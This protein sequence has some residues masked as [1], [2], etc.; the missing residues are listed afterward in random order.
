[1]A[2]EEGTIRAQAKRAK[3]ENRNGKE[4]SVPKDGRERMDREIVKAVLASPL[5]TPWPNIPSHLQKGVL[6]ALPKLVPQDIA[7]YHVSR[8]RCHQKEK[9]HK[10]K[11]LKPTQGQDGNGGSVGDAESHAESSQA[12]PARPVPPSHLAYVVLGIN[13]TIKELERNIDSLKL[14]LTMIA[15][16]LNA[17][18]T[19]TM[20]TSG[21]LPTAP[22]SPSP[23]IAEAAPLGWIVVPLLSISPRSLVSPIPQY[24]A[25]YNSLVYQWSQLGKTVRTRLKQ[26]KWGVLGYE[27]EEIR[28]V[29]LGDVEADMAKIAG[30]RR[31]A[32]IG[33]RAS[34]PDSKM[35]HDL[36]PKS[37]L[38]PPRHNITLPFP[39]SGLKVYTGER[40]E[41]KTDDPPAKKAKTSSLPIPNVHY[42]P[43]AVKGITTTV[44][45]DGNAKKQKRLAEVKK[46]RLEVKEKKKD[47]R[48][49]EFLKG[50]KGDKPK[51]P[52]HG[53]KKGTKKA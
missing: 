19:S 12:L 26:D 11:L 35:L 31:L 27:R 16:A 4:E 28:M 48:R 2:G 21:L 5:V 32:C 13:E 46:R 37:I 41:D 25:T 34:H 50:I 33:I 20:P 36:L 30:L 3:A 22:R 49:K 38:H 18:H 24:C 14:R 15:D 8:A 7:D 9:K 45:T 52:R 43:L 17:T 51:V 6:S 40:N 47:E 42:A 39:T 1:M 29:P 53:P 10:R 44:P 23:D